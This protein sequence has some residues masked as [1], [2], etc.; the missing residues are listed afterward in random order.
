LSINKNKN[1]INPF[2]ALFGVYNKSEKREAPKKGEKEEDNIEPIDLWIY[3]KNKLFL[4]IR[5]SITKTL[6]E[7]DQQKDEKIP[8]TKDLPKFNSS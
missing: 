3:N 1:N 7:Y 5:T 4:T 6:K 2:L 8:H